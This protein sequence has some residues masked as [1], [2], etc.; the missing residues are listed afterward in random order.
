M[1]RIHWLA[2]VVLLAG[3]ARPA[4][5]QEPAELAG[6]AR[7]VLKAHCARCHQ[8]EKSSSGM[9]FDV[10]K[11]DTLVKPD[12]DAPWVVGSSLARSPLWDAVEKTVTDGKDRFRMPQRGSRSSRRRPRR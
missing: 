12:G 1:T 5:A 6:K 2:A 7:Q 4:G 8:G 3:V 11:H 9:P 10:T